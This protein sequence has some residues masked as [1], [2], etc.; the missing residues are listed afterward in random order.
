MFLRLF[1]AVSLLLGNL[2]AQ[3]TPITY[4]LTASASGNLNGT[5]FFNQSVSLSYFGDTSNVR[6]IPNTFGILYENVGGQT[7]ISIGGAA[8]VAFTGPRQI[9]SVYQYVSQ[10]SA[11]GEVEFSADNNPTFDL[12]KSTSLATNAAVLSSYTGSTAMG[13]VVGMPVFVEQ[14]VSFATNAGLLFFS[15]AGSDASFTATTA[16]SITPE[17]SSIALLGTGLLG[18]GAAMRRRFCS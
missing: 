13:P 10:G 1:I 8:P 16:S 6:Q 12:V 5:P 18:V 15:S 9:F 7:F 3:A 2:A 11:F 4:N 14:G 17:P